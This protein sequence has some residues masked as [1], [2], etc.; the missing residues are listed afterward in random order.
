VEKILEVE[1][2]KRTRPFLKEA[3]FS[4]PWEKGPL[5]ERRREKRSYL[6]SKKDA[7]QSLHEKEEKRGKKRDSY[8]DHS[9]LLQLAAEIGIGRF[10]SPSRRPKKKKAVR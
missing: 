10:A 1:E 2:R 5:K 9:C 8:K 3:L 4:F 7:H 6:S